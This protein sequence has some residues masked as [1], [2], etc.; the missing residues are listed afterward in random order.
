MHLWEALADRYRDNPWVAGYNPLNE[1]ADS[2]GDA[3]GPFYERLHAAI[4][5]VDPGARALPGRQPLRHRVRRVRRA[6]AEH[7][8]HRARLR[9]RRASPTAATTRGLARPVRRPR[10]TSRPG[11]CTARST[12]AAPA[13]RSGS[14]SSARCTAATR[15]ATTPATACCDDQLDIYDEHAAGWSLWT[16]KDIGLQGV[17]H[18]AADSAYLQRIAP[19]LE[20]KARLGVDVVGRRR[21]R[22]AAHPRPDRSAR[23]AEEFPDFD[24]FPFGQQ[25]WIHVLVRHILLAEPMVHDFARCFAGIDAEE[26]RGAGRLLRVRT[27]RGAPAP[28]RRPGEA[29]V[30]I[31]RIETLVRGPL[32]IVRVGTDDGVVGIGQTAPYEAA[33]SAHVLHTMV[34]PLFLGRDPWDVETLVDECLRVHYKFPSSFLHRGARRGRHGAV[35]RA[36][37]RHG[38]AGGEAPGRPRPGVRTDVR[39]QHAAVDHAGAGGRSPR[40]VRRRAGLP[41]GEDPCRRGD[42]PRRRRGTGPH[43]ADRPARARGAGRRR[44]HLGRRQRRVLR[45][46]RDPRGQAP[47]GARVLPLRGAVPVPGARADRAGGRRPATSPSRAGSRTSRCR[48]STA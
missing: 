37:H 3:I 28:G 36:G 32:A 48:S 39:I 43:R 26:A 5:A 21:H 33:T 45:R 11:S 9:A 17:V 40:R 7:R 29:P 18:A 47:G 22:R 13:R 34:A 1:P 12:C 6:V 16:Y 27:L 31:T 4:R 35:G 20:K 38:P 14:A 19:V 23:C 15:S 10:R 25:Q 2:D 46:P 41:R 24:P 44:G 42:G 30:K 8:L